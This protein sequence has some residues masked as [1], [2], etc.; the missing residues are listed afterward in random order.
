MLRRDENLGCLL[1]ML[2]CC[3]LSDCS[4]WKEDPFDTPA[5]SVP[6][7]CVLRACCVRAGENAHM[8]TLTFFL[9]TCLLLCGQWSIHE[10]KLKV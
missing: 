8:F 5:G 1:A 3:G 9:F 7:A 10:A 2:W 4:N 6:A